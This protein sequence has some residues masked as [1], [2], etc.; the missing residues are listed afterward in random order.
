[1]DKSDKTILLALAEK[2]SA[3]EINTVLQEKYRNHHARSLC[4]NQVST[5][6]V[7]VG[8]YAFAKCGEII[9]SPNKNDL[10]RCIGVV[11]Y[12]DY[13]DPHHPHG[14]IVSLNKKL[15]TWCCEGF[16][17]D[18]MMKKL[19]LSETNGFQNT[20]D[21][22]TYSRKNSLSFLVAQYCNEYAEHGIRGWYLGSIEEYK[23]CFT[24]LRRVS[25][26]L[27]DKLFEENSFFWSSSA[28][29]SCNGRC[30]EYAVVKCIGFGDGK[31]F[32]DTYQNIGFE[33]GISVCTVFP[34]KLF[35]LCRPL[36]A[37]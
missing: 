26:A 16:E 28:Y 8:Y 19:D 15:L 33:D 6:I 22:I 35:P 12:V 32:E 11:G 13:S 1:M 7:D 5:H 25:F 24:E 3:E 21:I 17:A 14:L 20:A 36:L 18:K 23:K 27:A 9:F 34:E 31:V 29:S 4:V 30:E 10:P 37:F 2:Y